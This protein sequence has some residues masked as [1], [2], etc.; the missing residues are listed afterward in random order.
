MRI[1]HAECPYANCRWR[2]DEPDISNDQQRRASIFHHADIDHNDMQRKLR[3]RSS[4]DIWILWIEQLN[5]YRFNWTLSF[6]Q[7]AEVSLGT[8]GLLIEKV[9]TTKEPVAQ[10]AAWIPV[11]MQEGLSVRDMAVEQRIL[12]NYRYRRRHALWFVSNCGPKQRFEYYQQLQQFYPIRTFGQCFESK[13]DRDH[14]CQS[15]QSYLA[16]FYLAFESQT[17]KDYVTEKFWRAIGFGMIPIVLGPSKQS[18]LDLNM[19]SSAF[20]HVDDFPS[21]KELA[22]HLH[23]I[24]NNYDLYREYFQ[25]WHRYEVFNDINDLEAIRMCEL[26]MLLNK[27]TTSEHSFYSNIN[28]W[29]RTAC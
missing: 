6:R 8:Y 15:E 22:I 4:N 5:R 12:M 23:R 3:H 1:F 18:Y 10:Q 28:R 11:H 24:E 27:Q 19:P 20:I 26:C 21:S 14:S 25:W 16:M 9:L 2:C 17:C 13:C 7:D 29:Y